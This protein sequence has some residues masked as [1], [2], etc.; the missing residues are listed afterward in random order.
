MFDITPVFF[1]KTGKCSDFLIFILDNTN[2]KVLWLKKQKSREI[3]SAFY[4]FYFSG[5]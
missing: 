2:F 1:R 3:F 5:S 4:K